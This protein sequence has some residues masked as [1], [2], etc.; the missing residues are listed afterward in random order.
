MAG[1]SIARYRSM[2]DGI[3]S[4]ADYV[5]MKANY[6][7]EIE[8]LSE[9]ANEIRNSRYKALAQ[10]KE[11]YSFA[12]ATAAVLSNKKFTA[13]LIEHLVESVHVNPDKSVRISL[14]YRNEFKEAA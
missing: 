11:Y 1:F 9:R 3:I 14:K 12:D 7:A 4:E 13:E 8:K 6:T 5:R 2:V 10:V